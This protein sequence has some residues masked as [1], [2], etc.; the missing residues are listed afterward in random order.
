MSTLR[1]TTA[2][3]LASLG[4]TS[5]AG[6][7]YFE[8]TNNRIVVWSGSAWTL[9]NNDGVAAPFANASSVSL[10]GT[11]DHMTTATSVLNFYT[12]GGAV[13]AW[14]RPS[15]VTASN[16]N[17]AGN[18]SIIS[19]GSVYINFAINESGV[20]NLYFYDGSVRELTATSTVSTTDWMHVCYTW[21]TSGCSI[22]VNGTS[23]ASTTSFTPANVSSG[24]TSAAVY[25]GKT[26]F[27][28]ANHLGGLID[29]VSLFNAELSSSE[30][31]ELINAG[32]GGANDTP[33][34]IDST[35]LSP[36]NWW[37][38]GDYSG[39]TSGSTVTDQGSG[40]NNLTLQNGAS[41]STTVP[42]I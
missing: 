30:V 20:P 10:D 31:N 38:M 15:S 6:D 35:S 29:E 19:K 33:A 41:F 28:G 12:G 40:S 9:Y 4:A 23:E 7:T 2:A 24:Q 32:T 39:D 14:I 5:N 3:N 27:S 1:T 25:L 37:R 11:N 22:Y 36:V 34:D 21:S 13:S 26:T 16:T 8:T 17:G 18:R 42:T